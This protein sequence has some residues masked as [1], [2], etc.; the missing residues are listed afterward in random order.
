MEMK[1]CVG[2]GYI[3]TVNRV[4][5]TMP[6]VVSIIVFNIRESSTVVLLATGHMTTILFP[7]A[8]TYCAGIMTQEC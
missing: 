4:T 1:D 2:F 8:V 3:F 5:V 7:G 6:S